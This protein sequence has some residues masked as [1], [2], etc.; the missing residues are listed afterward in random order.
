MYPL[1]LGIVLVLL[2]AVNTKPTERTYFN[3]CGINLE[4]EEVF[5]RRVALQTEGALPQTRPQKDLTPSEIHP[6]VVSFGTGGSKGEWK[7][8]CGGSIISPHFVLTTH[9]C[10]K[11]VGRDGQIRAG[12]SDLNT[13]AQDSTN[14]QVVKVAKVFVHPL[15]DEKSS[16]AYYDVA[17]LGLDPPLVFTGSVRHICLPKQPKLGSDSRKAAAIT[18]AGYGE[19]KVGSL[20]SVQVTVRPEKYCK[21][22]YES[23]LVNQAKEALAKEATR[24]PT[25]ED[26]TEQ[27]ATVETVGPTTSEENITSS[28]TTT[29][30]AIVEENTT[31]PAATSKINV[32]AIVGDKM[33]T[34]PTS[35]IK[36]DVPPTSLW[37]NFTDPSSRDLYQGEIE[38]P[39]DREI[40]ADFSTTEEYSTT[41]ISLNE[42]PKKVVDQSVLDIKTRSKRQIKTYHKWL[43]NAARMISEKF[44]SSVLCIGSELRGT[45]ACDG[46]NGGPGYVF[47]TSQRFINVKYL[48]V[49]LF[50]GSV[51]CGLAEF[52]EIYVNLEQADILD[53]VKRFAPGGEEEILALK[54][55]NSKQE[56]N[57][58]ESN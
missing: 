44:N 32:S 28:P 3:G 16:S 36:S 27:P 21:N 17:V 10:T 35:A 13:S 47:D 22:I 45:G 1:I 12:D 53:F 43:V 55:W 29:C 8:V 11:H 23:K 57:N 50:H 33:T 19:S 54:E 40:S 37:N 42:E 25:T 49:A 18:V 14:V 46:D 7:H 56:K 2:S 5:K 26:P 9:S 15:R 38:Q 20:L 58:I 52:P 48:Q 4:L 51:A 6:W 39:A 31:E 30:A 24:G 34:E 41:G